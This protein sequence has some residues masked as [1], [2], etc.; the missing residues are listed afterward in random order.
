MI[1]SRKTGEP[2]RSGINKAHL[3]LYKALYF[4]ERKG[5]QF[6]KED[7]LE[8]HKKYVVPNKVRYDAHLRTQEQKYHNASS[9]MNKAM[10]VLI[11]RGYLGLTFKKD[12]R[13]LT[14]Q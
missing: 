4:A 2:R 13:C 10:S 14:E 1:V 3:E 12:L 7:L 8:L 6:T 11:R 5:T 9:W